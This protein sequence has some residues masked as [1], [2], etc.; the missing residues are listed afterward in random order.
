[1]E[2]ELPEGLRSAAARRSRSALRLAQATFWLACA[3]VAVL[4]LLPT[5]YLQSGLFDWWD[6]AQHALAFA[7]LGFVGLTAY[8]GRSARVIAGLLAFA[9]A[10][11]LA[12]ATTGWRIGEM[13]DLLADAV[14]LSVG[15]LAWTFARRRPGAGRSPVLQR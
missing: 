9:A 7:V 3:T 8:P 10:I 13:T 1:M 2:V 6:K 5:A 11:E 14:G 4:S 12:Q 15:W